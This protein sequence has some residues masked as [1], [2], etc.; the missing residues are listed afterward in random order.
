[1]NPIE[2]DAHGEAVNRS[3]ANL[4]ILA[5]AGTDTYADLVRMHPEQACATANLTAQEI[6]IVKSQEIPSD[7]P[8]TFCGI[9]V[10]QRVELP[11]DRIDF[12]S[13]EQH[14]GSIVNLKRLVL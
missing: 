10:K 7:L 8:M 11:P 3:L 1:M 5:L 4:L 9:P 12:F 6:A 2:I 13:G 14:V